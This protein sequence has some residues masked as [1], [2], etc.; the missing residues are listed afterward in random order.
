MKRI[1][2]VL[3]VILAM[4]QISFSQVKKESY[5]SVAVARIRDEGLNRSQVMRLFSGLTDVYGP[6]LSGSPAYLEAAE[7][8]RRQLEAMG[9]AKARLEAWGPW[10]K[11]W[12]LKNYSAMVSGRQNFPLLSYPK[13]WS[14]SMGKVTADLVYLNAQTDSA[15]KTF[16][17]KIKGK[18]ILVDDAR[19]LTPPFE[20]AAR[21]TADSTLLKLANSDGQRRGGRWFD[22][23]PDAARRRMI[24]FRKISLCFDEAAK[25][26]LTC[27]D[28]NG[29]IIDVASAVYPQHPDSG[30]T[31]GPKAFQNDAPKMIPQVSVG[32]EHYN[33]LVRL[34]QQGESLRLTLEIEAAF[35]Q[36]DSCYNILAEIP[37]T[38]L[39]DEIVI[40]GGHFDSWHGGTGAA[41]NAA[42]CAVAMEAMRLI[43]ALD[44]RPRRTIRIG[45]WDAEEHGFLGSRGYIA[46][47]L[48]TREGGAENR[49]G[50]VI[51]KPE[52][53]KFSVYFNMDNGGGKFRGI[54]LQGN[55]ACR[56]IFRAWLV[57]FNDLG[58][59]TISLANT[60]GT[61]HQVFD[62]LGLPGFQFIQDPLDYGSR[63][64]HTDMDVFERCLP[65]DLK[66]AAVI[67][68]AFAYNAA[69]RDEKIPR[70]PAAAARE[71]R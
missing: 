23:G 45:L 14:P 28:R 22:R 1:E 18:F 7:W 61:D 8:A 32:A 11:G 37:G 26:I 54:Y 27:S 42:G 55:E 12:T 62:G 19:E 53:E 39:Q 30:W 3:A 34:L 49:N 2:C 51:Y 44:L 6:R 52:G 21:R 68:A 50:K 5:D 70:K 25:A 71:P 20:P 46:K 10:G 13:A 24:A 58:A 43:K 66:Q 4:V 31:R 67:M 63:V 17:G 36:V 41:D 33:R 57:P 60:G 64:H 16:S 35:N 47:H 9:L 59:A 15:L 40:V 29:G 65:D 48:A 38:D 56:P 69:M